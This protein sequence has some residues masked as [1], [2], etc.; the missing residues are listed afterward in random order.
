[1]PPDHGCV[2]CYQCPTGEPHMTRF[3]TRLARASL[4][5]VYNDRWWETRHAGLAHTSE[6]A[7]FP[8]RVLPLYS[9]TLN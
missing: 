3:V 7:E 1:M 6:S 4:M 8:A 2:G 9:R 5:P